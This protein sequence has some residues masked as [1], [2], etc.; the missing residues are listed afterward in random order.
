MDALGIAYDDYRLIVTGM[1]RAWCLLAAADL[2]QGRHAKDLAQSGPF[3]LQ[4]HRARIET[5]EQLLARGY[6]QELPR[7]GPHRLYVR[8][9]AGDLFL[10]KLARWQH[11]EQATVLDWLGRT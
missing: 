11:Y 2:T 4:E 5:V 10:S 7:T 1:R 3:L 6:L 9:P 8:T